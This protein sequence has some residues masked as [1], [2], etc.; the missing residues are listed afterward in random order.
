MFTLALFVSLCVLIFS[1]NLYRT[2]HAMTD[3]SD[4]DF[5]NGID[6]EEIAEIS[7]ERLPI[8]KSIIESSIGNKRSRENRTPVLNYWDTLK[9]NLS[10]TP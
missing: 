9:G 2:C 10:L 6:L 5:F 1:N 7:I 3:E 8:F 4:A